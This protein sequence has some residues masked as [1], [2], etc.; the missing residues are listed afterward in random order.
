MDYEVFLLSRIKEEYDRTGDNTSA[1]ER[2]LQRTG[3]IVT[4]AALLLAIVFIAFSTSSVTTIKLMGIGVA[5]A[6]L[7][8]AT[9]VRGLLVPAFMRLAGDWNWWAPSSLRRLHRRFGL[10]EG[11]DLI[12]DARI[13]P[14]PVG[15][16]G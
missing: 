12:V 10:S 1:V 6:I 7:M 14:T 15:S 2:G 4:A 9:L 16:S 5:L 13:D 11:D 3:R 8:D